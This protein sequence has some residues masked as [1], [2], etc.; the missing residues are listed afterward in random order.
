MRL[1]KVGKNEVVMEVISKPPL[2][3]AIG[4]E[5]NLS[6]AHVVEQLVITTRMC[7]Q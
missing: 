7:N 3:F 5:G 4:L 2:K 6:R 1:L